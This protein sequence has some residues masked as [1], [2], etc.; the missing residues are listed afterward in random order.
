VWVEVRQWRWL[1]DAWGPPQ[2]LHRGTELGVE[3]PLSNSPPRTNGIKERDM[4]TSLHSIW[5]S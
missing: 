5:P 1:A 2:H 4:M 3:G